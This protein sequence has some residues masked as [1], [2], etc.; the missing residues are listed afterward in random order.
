MCH[1]LPLRMCHLLLFES[2]PIDSSPEQLVRRSRRLRRPPDCYP[3]LAFTATALS[4]LASYHDFFTK[5]QTR[6]H[7]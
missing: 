5:A 1:L 6:A 2:S 7:H 3:P 4:E